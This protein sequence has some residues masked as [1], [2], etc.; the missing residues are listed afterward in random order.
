MKLLYKPFALIAKF[1][2]GRLS[3]SLF[4]SLWGR[5]DDE[6]P[7]LPGTG[8]ATTAKVVGA[9]AL[10]GAVMAGTAAV[11]NRTFARFFH[12]LIGAWP[13]K[14]PAPEPDQD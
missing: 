13:E 8:E 1:V 14:R 11:V 5:V 7:P 9:Q 4:K 6:P 3:R 2:I 10:Q 12:H